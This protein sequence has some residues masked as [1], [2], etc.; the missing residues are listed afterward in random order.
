MFTGWWS[1]RGGRGRW[2]ESERGRR[3][4]AQENGHGARDPVRGFSFDGSILC[5]VGNSEFD[6][7]MID[8]ILTVGGEPHV[9]ESGTQHCVVQPW[10]VMSQSHTT[11]TGDARPQLGAVALD[12]RRGAG[13]SGQQRPNLEMWP[14]STTGG[15]FLPPKV[16][17]AIS[18]QPKF[19]N[20]KFFW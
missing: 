15:Q 18:Q 6:G 5:L 7:R 12:T 2:G 9:S 8:F 16:K 20:F 19:F 10:L 13:R 14:P 3:E 17:G 4:L 11:I 1:W